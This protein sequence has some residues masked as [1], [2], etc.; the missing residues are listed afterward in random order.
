MVYI[1]GQEGRRG[2]EELNSEAVM[3]GFICG[4]EYHHQEYISC[5][6]Q[7]EQR[8]W[9]S[10]INRTHSDK[11]QWVRPSDS[12][13]DADEECKEIE[14]SCAENH[15]VKDLRFPRYASTT[16]RSPYLLQ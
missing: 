16:F 11:Y 12:V 9:F 3:V 5:C 10:M 15:K 14:V 2:E 7:D 8:L 4:S 1:I 13:V 6:Q